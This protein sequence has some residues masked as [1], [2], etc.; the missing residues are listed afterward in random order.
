MKSVQAAEIKAPVL[1]DLEM[2]E[3]DPADL[4]RYIADSKFRLHAAITCNPPS[5]K[6]DGRY[7][8]DVGIRGGVAAR[9][10]SQGATADAGSRC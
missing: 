6:F 3:A 10:P 8:R 9:R 4:Y 2:G 7:N 1:T 5:D